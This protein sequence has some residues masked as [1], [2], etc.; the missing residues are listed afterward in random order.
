MPSVKCRLVVTEIVKI[1]AI[2]SLN[3]VDL[4]DQCLRLNS[5]RPACTL[6]VNYTEDKGKE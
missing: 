5:F 1:I 2:N 3:L 6:T 4:L